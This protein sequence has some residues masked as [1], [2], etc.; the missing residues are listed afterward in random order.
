MTY[1]KEQNNK[2]TFHTSFR[3]SNL[4]KKEQSEVE[5][6]LDMIVTAKKYII[7]GKIL[8]NKGE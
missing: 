3:N 6:L 1:N 2:S 4:T 8:Y 7:L 5:Y